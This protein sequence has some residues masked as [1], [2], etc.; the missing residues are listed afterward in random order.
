[1]ITDKKID[2]DTVERTTESKQQFTKK[3]LLDAKANLQNQID[4]INALLDLLKYDLL[5]QIV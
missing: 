3:E 5:K 2:A 4:E 1:M